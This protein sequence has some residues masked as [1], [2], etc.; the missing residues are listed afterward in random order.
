MQKVIILLF[1]VKRYFLVISKPEY[2]DKGRTIRQFTLMAIEDQEGVF[3]CIDQ[4]GNEFFFFY[5]T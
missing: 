3:D 4:V 1:S 2:I 5:Q